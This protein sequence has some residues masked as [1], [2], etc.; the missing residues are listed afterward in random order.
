MRFVA[1][2]LSSVLC[3]TLC[4]CFVP[5][6]AFGLGQASNL[7]QLEDPSGLQADQDD[8]DSPEDSDGPGS[9]LAP[10]ASTLVG[11]EEAAQESTDTSAAVAK[12]KRKPHTKRAHKRRTKKRHGK[13]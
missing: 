2:R 7:H 10:D 4:A 9:P 12:R 8:T 1:R 3:V 6:L 13:A 11:S 5:N